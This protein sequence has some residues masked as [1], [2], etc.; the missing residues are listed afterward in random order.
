MDSRLACLTLGDSGLALMLEQAP[1]DAVGFQEI[2]LY[3]L[4]K[5]HDLCVCQ[6]VEQAARRGRSCT[7]TR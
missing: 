6:G 3:T 5:Y 7:P 4:G 1:S 2:E